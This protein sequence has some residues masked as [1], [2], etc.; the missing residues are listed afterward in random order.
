MN[1]VKTSFLNALA[2]FI[3]IVTALV[4]NKVL[5]VYVGPT[6][7][8]VIGQFQSLLA[9]L[10]TFASG[11]INT[12][13][14]KYTAEF[15]EDPQEQ[16]AIL[17]TAASISLLGA[18]IF[19]LLL[20]IFRKPLAVWMLADVR[21]S[22]VI[23]WLAAALVPMLLNGLFLAILNGRKAIKAYVIAN[24]VGSLVTAITA[25]ALVFKFGLY[26]VLVAMAISQALACSVTAWLFQRTCKVS[27]KSFLGRM[28]R[29]IAR[30]LGGFALMSATSA[31]AL[32]LAQMVIRD[33]LADRLGW[34]SVGLWQALWKISDMHLMLLTSTLS[35][36][37]LPR[38]SEIKSAAGLR[39][40]VMKGYR[41]VLP[42]VVASASIIYVL[43]EFFIRVLLTD[44]FFP[45]TEI[46]GWQMAGDVL[47]I[48]SWVVSCTMISHAR[49]RVFIITELIFT[50]LWVMLTLGGA[51]IDGLRGAAIGYVLTYSAY[52]VVVFYL[53]F[54][55]LNKIRQNESVGV[56]L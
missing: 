56:I 44:E 19:A 23:L 46:I 54:N 51:E 36:Y 2:V 40:E 17:R 49:V 12:G 32:P 42:L 43:R 37:F 8:A 7:Y 31:V 27:W 26:G 10:S 25:T 47:K 21:L 45:L 16:E 53:F 6:G 13:V 24:I 22:S 20:V 9:M 15:H 35:L 30:R 50:L 55:L 38:F 14:T 41:F 18:T 33:G 28:D 48:S 34:H 11:G 1:L 52:C 3:K 29:G 4:L 39:S 5:A